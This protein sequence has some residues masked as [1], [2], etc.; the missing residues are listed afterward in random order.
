MDQFTNGMI[1]LIQDVVHQ[2]KSAMTYMYM[3]KFSICENDQFDILKI[4]YHGVS[5]H[6]VEL[7]IDSSIIEVGADAL[8]FSLLEIFYFG[9]F[10]TTE[11]DNRFIP[12]ENLLRKILQK[13]T[14]DEQ[15]KIRLS[16]IDFSRLKQTFP[17]YGKEPIWLWKRIDKKEVELQYN[18]QRQIITPFNTQL[19]VFYEKS[20]QDFISDE[21]VHYFHTELLDCDQLK[22]YQTNYSKAFDKILKE[23]RKHL[24]EIH[25]HIKRTEGL[26]RALIE[27]GRLKSNYQQI[28]HERYTKFDKEQQFEFRFYGGVRIT[29]QFDFRSLKNGRKMKYISAQLKPVLSLRLWRDNL[30]EHYESEQ[31]NQTK[32]IRRI[33][34]KLRDSIPVYGLRKKYGSK[35]FTFNN[36]TF[37]GQYK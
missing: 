23:E 5:K 26:H 17:G 16:V 28:L 13:V 36:L 15:I 22:L 18:E 2:T 7:S 9:A 31:N 20:K 24:N 4:A 10:N 25:S 37:R 8:S 29:L 1:F 33:K 11:K 32:L 12:L 6:E 30:W 3:N 34:I 27:S 35:I 14:I 21:V 19:D